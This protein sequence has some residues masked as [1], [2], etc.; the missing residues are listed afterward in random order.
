MRAVQ[1]WSLKAVAEACGCSASLIG[2]W[3]KGH[4][5]V[6]VKIQGQ[7]SHLWSQWHSRDEPVH[8]QQSQRCSMC[9]DYLPHESFNRD[10]TKKSGYQSQCKPCS[11][12]SAG[13]WYQ[14]NRYVEPSKRLIQKIFRG[15]HKR[16]AGHHWVSNIDK[17]IKQL[18][19]LGANPSEFHIQSKPY[20]CAPS[21]VD[22]GDWKN[23]PTKHKN[24]KDTAN[25]GTE[26]LRRDKKQNPEIVK[27]EYSWY[28][29]VAEKLN[30]LLRQSRATEEQIR[31]LIKLKCR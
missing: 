4:C 25:R 9:W 13:D 28:D 18:C 7:L 22:F 23:E 31:R 16:L 2:K 27:E 12:K 10:S 26:I 21:D 3:E 15:T 1:D 14:K 24:Q 5:R 11:R 20:T 29:E 30:E 6:S 8:P 19:N 17:E